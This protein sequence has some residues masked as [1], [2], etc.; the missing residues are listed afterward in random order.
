MKNILLP[1][2]YEYLAGLVNE[3]SNESKKLTKKLGEYAAH[4]G[5]VPFQIPEYQ[6]TDDKLRSIKERF[7]VI[8]KLLK[9]SDVVTFEKIDDRVI[10]LYCFIKTEDQDTGFKD[11]FYIIHPEL[12]DKI[13]FKDETLPVSPKS[14][15]GQALIGKKSGNVVKIKLP[16]TTKKLKIISFEKKEF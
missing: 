16:K 6:A 10:G 1:K 2:D 8:N 9:N 15:V 3:L 5:A 12:A 11:C 7:I 13:E 14:P 4:G